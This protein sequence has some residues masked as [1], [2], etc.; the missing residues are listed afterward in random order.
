MPAEIWRDIPGYEGAYQVSSL[1][2]VRSMDRMVRVC[3]HGLEAKR[4]VKGRVLRPGRTNSG[5]LSVVLGHGAHGSQVHDLVARAFLGPRPEGMDI[6]HIDGDPT[7][8]CVDNLR[9]DT[10]TENILDVYRVGGRWRKLTL[11]DMREIK[12]LLRTGLSGVEIARLF[13]VS[14]STVSAIK[15][16]RYKSCVLL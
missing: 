4:L 7:N 6:C 14:P 8:N 12:E 16:G 1:G 11:E 15:V 9:Y 3:P 13:S 5:H 10:R 2:R